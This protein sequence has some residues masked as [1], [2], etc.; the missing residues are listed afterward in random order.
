M[1]IP[2]SSD[3][4]LKLK[5]IKEKQTRMDQSNWPVSWM[6]SM[7]GFSI[8]LFNLINWWDEEP[9]QERFKPKTLIWHIGAPRTNNFNPQINSNEFPNHASS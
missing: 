2:G 8:F 3:W 7:A 5:N 6:K 9:T 4:M 1:T